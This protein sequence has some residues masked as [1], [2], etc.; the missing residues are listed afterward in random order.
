MIIAC[1]ESEKY[2]RRD[3]VMGDT[4]ELWCK[5]TPSPGVK[6]TVNMTDRY[7]SGIYV[8][9]TNTVRHDNLIIQYNSSKEA[10]VL[11]IDNVHTKDSGLYDCY[12]VNGR[13]IIGFYLVAESM[14]LTVLGNIAVCSWCS[15]LC[16]FSA[17]EEAAICKLQLN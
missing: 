17:V 3:A 4:V 1:T 12:E 8:N 9:E 14:F 10:Y 13:R 7:L 11:R 16:N 5:T 15:N 2:H 6:W